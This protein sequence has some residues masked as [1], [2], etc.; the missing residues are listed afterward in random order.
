MYTRSMYRTDTSQRYVPALLPASLPAPA[1]AATLPSVPWRRRPALGGGAHPS[2]PVGDGTT[3]I[4]CRLRA[5]PPGNARVSAGWPHDAVRRLRRPSV[6]AQGREISRRG[7]RYRLPDLPESQAHSRHV[8]VWGRTRA[9]RG[10]GEASPRTSRDGVRIR[11]VPGVRGRGLPELCLEPPCVVL[12]SRHGRAT[13]PAQSA[14]PRWGM[15]AG[16]DD[17]SSAL[18]GWA[19]RPRL[20]RG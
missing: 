15:T 18:D 16:R 5:C 4:G 2:Y 11:R 6:P 3:A 10:P 14:C 7:D 9:I 13:H 19:G 12:R 1:A 17:V 20:G 8:R